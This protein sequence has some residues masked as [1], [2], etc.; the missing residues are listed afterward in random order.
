MDVL[1]HQQFSSKF[2]IFTAA[3]SSGRWEKNGLSFLSAGRLDLHEQCEKIFFDALGQCFSSF[4]LAIPKMFWIVDINIFQYIINIRWNTYY[5]P[6][7]WK[8]H[9][10]I[11]LRQRL[12]LN[13]CSIVEL[14]YSYF[15]DD[16]RSHNDIST[17]IVSAILKS[18]ALRFWFD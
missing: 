1:C 3:S 12:F 16:L 18:K 6:K 2:H 4:Y 10:H 15:E 7:N 5:N 13:L 17:S 9:N 8:N 14:P 11:S